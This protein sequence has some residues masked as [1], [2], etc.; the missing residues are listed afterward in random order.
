MS[1]YE[2]TGKIFHVRF[3]ENDPNRYTSSFQ[4]TV[5]GKIGII[6]GLN[7]IG[8]FK[9]IKDNAEN[10]MN[11]LGV[12]TIFFTMMPDTYSYL[13]KALDGKAI[14]EIVREVTAHNRV[15]LE[16]KLK[17]IGK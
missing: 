5:D 14:L 10:I 12:D 3:Y 2:I 16:I 17:L 8:F 13:S 4:M 15:M 7:G 9:G 11:D 6:Y 1:S